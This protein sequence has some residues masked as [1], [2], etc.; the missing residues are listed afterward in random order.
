MRRGWAGAVG[1]IATVTVA[2]GLAGCDAGDGTTLRD[3]IAPTTL[4]PP[5]TTP[6]SSVEVGD[7][8]AAPLPSLDVEASGGATLLPGA[9]GGGSTVTPAQGTATFQLFVPWAE[10]GPIDARYGCAGSNLS[11]P[12]SWVDLPAG[13]VE[14]A[15]ALVDESNLSNGRP[16]VHWLM[17]GIDPNATDA[18]LA[19]GEIPPGA[20]QALN[21]FGDVGYAGPCPNPGET[22]SYRV[23]L[24]ALGQQLE[25]TDGT[26]AADF[27]DQV[28]AVAVDRASVVGTST[29]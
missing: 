1:V 8:D 19:E 17:A 22:N 27:L 16:F 11:P 10:G 26:P 23:T 20:I 9:G 2:A 13:T 15:V 29:R 5:D 12:I 6:L 28:E 24:F 14:L 3:T 25:V 4:P 18:T 21:F 7:S